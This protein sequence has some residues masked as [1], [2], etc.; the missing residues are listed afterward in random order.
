MRLSF[1]GHSEQAILSLVIRL[2]D[3][4]MRSVPV[5]CSENDN[6]AILYRW[7]MTDTNL[8][9]IPGFSFASPSP[10]PLQYVVIAPHILLLPTPIP[11]PA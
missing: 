4:V 3:K 9:A 8:P 10:M 1:A 5:A 2:K 7:I 6:E 11:A